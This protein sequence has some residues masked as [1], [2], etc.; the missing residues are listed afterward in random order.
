[1]RHFKTISEF[2]EFR[3][4]PKPAHPLI[5]V[6]EASVVNQL[7]REEPL[8]LVV[9]FYVI[10]VKRVANLRMRYGQQP[11]D[12]NEGV[13]SFVAPNQ[14][15][16]MGRVDEKKGIKQ[17]GWVLLL[18]PDFLWNTPLAKTIKD[19]DFW[20]YSLHEALF[21]SKK[22][23]AIVHGIMQGIRQEYHPS[24]D[25]FSR[26]IIVSQ[27]ETLL[28]YSERFY[29]RQFI[30]REKVNYQ[31]LD[32][33]EKLLDDYFTRD[34]L[35]K[36]G[37]PTVQAIAEQ[38]HLSPKYLSNLLQTLMGQSTQQ[39]IHDKLIEK[40]KERLAATQLPI[41]Q[42]AYGLGFEHSQSFSK[43]FKK[44]TKLSPLEFRLSFY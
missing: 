11:F 23:E 27:L 26:Q 17:S 13:M 10:A 38:L 19:Y 16:S 2:Y 20:D 31:L 33:L 22:E 12:F 25:K 21:L 7:H 40:A 42:I 18:H 9:G 3:N 41:S 4:L 44:K 43:L 5:S 1:M 34:D 35:M 14:V 8:S 36:Q 15:T 32:R 29:N 28:N 37:L 30:T 39:R 6:I 24:L